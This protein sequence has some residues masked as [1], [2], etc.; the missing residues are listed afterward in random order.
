MRIPALVLS[1]VLLSS[2]VSAQTRPGGHFDLA[3]LGLTPS[4]MNGEEVYPD[5]DLDGNRNTIE[6]IEERPDPLGGFIRHLRVGR[7]TSTAPV[8]VC[9]GEWFNP[10][11]AVLAYTEAR[12]GTA[13]WARHRLANLGG[14]YVI[15]YRTSNGKFGWLDFDLPE[16]K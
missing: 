7:V 6:L 2:V 5:F 11:V 15:W 4:F 1:C 8:R 13:V 3:A 14:R 12:Y 16:C 9:M 10:I